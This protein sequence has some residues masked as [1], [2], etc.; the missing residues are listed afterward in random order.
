MLTTAKYAIESQIAWHG[1]DP[2]QSMLLVGPDEGEYEVS[3]EKILSYIDNHAS[4]L[5]LV[6]LP[7]IQYY[8]GQLFDIKRI[9]E[10]AQSLEIGRAHV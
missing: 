5:A 8:T 3:T 9:T 6:L 4:E 2:D 10:Y 7:G 1:L